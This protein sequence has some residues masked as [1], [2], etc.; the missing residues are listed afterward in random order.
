MIDSFLLSNTAKDQ[1]RSERDA[2]VEKSDWKTEACSDKCM[3][4]SDRQASY[5]ADWWWITT[6][7]R[8]VQ[9]SQYYYA[10]NNIKQILH[11]DLSIRNFDLLI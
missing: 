11:E 5:L 2:T 1:R 8:W 6:A 9:S 4:N 3:K 10:W 7:R